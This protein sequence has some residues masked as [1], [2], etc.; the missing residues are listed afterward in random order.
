MK[1]LLTYLV[2]DL[3]AFEKRATEH[4]ELT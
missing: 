2:T 1:K 4:A 3:F